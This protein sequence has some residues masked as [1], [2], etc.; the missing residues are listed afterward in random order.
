[1]NP[2]QNIST[3]F[4][5]S[6]I[7]R[8]IWVKIF[9]WSWAIVQKSPSNLLI[10]LRHWKA[11][12]AWYASKNYEND[13]GRFTYG[14]WFYRE[15]TKFVKKWGLSK[16]F[17]VWGNSSRRQHLRQHWEPYKNKC[18]QKNIPVNHWAIPRATLKNM[19]AGKLDA[20]KDETQTKLGFGKMTVPREFTRE[21]ILEAVAKLIATDDQVRSK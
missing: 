2:N 20:K 10:N 4:R 17:H 11:G 7:Q 13:T 6:Y 14:H 9:Y 3:L 21:G 8:K 15:D 5:R 18:E 12:G 19:E 1:M 16:A